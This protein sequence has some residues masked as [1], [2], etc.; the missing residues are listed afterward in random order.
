MGHTTSY[1]P[2]NVQLSHAERL[3][4]VAEAQCACSTREDGLIVGQTPSYS[5][6]NVQ[7]SHANVKRPDSV[8]EAQCT[9]STGEC[10]F[11]VGQTLNYWPSNVQ[12]SHVKCSYSVAEAQ[13]TCTREDGLIVRETSTYLTTN[14][15]NS[16]AGLNLRVVAV[17]MDSLWVKRPVIR[18]STSSSLT[19]DVQSEV[20]RRL[21][22]C[23]YLLY[24]FGVCIKPVMRPIICF[25]DEV[26]LLI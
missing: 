9:C 14:V 11:I 15:Q 3:Y 1:S 5:T 13:R 18:R 10:A 4:S 26:Y 23:Y 24:V 16:M 22:T 2:S 21:S 17:S 8:A 19:S 25:S 7:T 12:L 6:P 20:W